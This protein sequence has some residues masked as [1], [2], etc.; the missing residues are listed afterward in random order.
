[1]QSQLQILSDEEQQK[2]LTEAGFKVHGVFESSDG[3]SR[4]YY[5]TKAPS[6]AR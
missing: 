3:L 4:F 1:M 2:L 6:G 5:T